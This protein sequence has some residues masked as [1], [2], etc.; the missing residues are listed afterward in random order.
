MA[1]EIE[2][3]VAPKRLRM[4]S[5]L[6]VAL[7]IITGLVL[8]QAIVAFPTVVCTSLGTLTVNLQLCKPAD[9][10]VGW[11]PSYRNNMD[12]IDSQLGP[13]ATPQLSSLGLGVPA[14][15]AGSLKMTGK[16][17]LY[18][19]AAPL[20]GQL[21]I[22]GTASGTY[23]PATLTAGSG[24][25]ITNGNNTVTITGLAGIF[26]GEF[27][28]SDQTVT[29]SSVLNVAHGLGAK[30]KLVQVS[31]KNAT[32]EGGFS[33]GDEV[34]VMGLEQTGAIGTTVS[35][36]ATNV[37][38]ITQSQ[39]RILGKTGPATEIVVTPANWKYVVRAWK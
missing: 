31:L 6:T 7:A 13:N 15:T 30:P 28:S 10:E 34:P 18:N 8:G 16:I 5:R 21:L 37:S 12:L 1:F 23:T 2:T 20:D 33:V 27:L 38:V 9:G 29:V 24:I 3:T 19:N 11:G 14:G 35:F 17:L 4:I 32:T 26:A 39:I 36:D 22:G 25:T